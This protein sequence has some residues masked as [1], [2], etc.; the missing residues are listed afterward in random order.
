MD[1][2]KQGETYSTELELSGDDVEAFAYTMSVLQFPDDTPAITRALTLEDGK[3]QIDLTSAET[4]ALAVGQWAI[5]VQSADSDEDIRAIEYIH[6][7]K[8]W[9]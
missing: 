8:G 4:A 5:H 9:V 7:A 6:V 1:V 3:A 2:V